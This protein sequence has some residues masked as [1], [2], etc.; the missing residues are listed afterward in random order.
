MSESNLSDLLCG[1]VVVLRG[2]PYDEQISKELKKYSKLVGVEQIIVKVKDTSGLKGTTGQWVKTDKE[3][4]WIDK[5]WYK[6][7]TRIIC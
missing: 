6:R 1:D 4:E 5:I 3:P 2:C 7:S